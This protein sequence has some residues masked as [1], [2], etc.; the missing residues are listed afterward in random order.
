MSAVLR[1]GQGGLSRGECAGIDR[2]AMAML[3]PFIIMQ[4]VEQKEA[5]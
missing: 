4:R 3:K 1:G 5:A 2:E